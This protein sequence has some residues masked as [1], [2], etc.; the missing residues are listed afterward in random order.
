MQALL[1]LGNLLLGTGDCA[2]AVA[3]YDALLA[4]TPGGHWRAC[5]F[6]ASALVS[7]GRVEE[8]CQALHIASQTAGPLA[9][10]D[11]SLVSKSL[12][13]V[14]YWHEHGPDP[15]IVLHQQRQED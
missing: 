10:P 1:N 12:T 2:E 5:L 15:Q 13:A 14:L 4:A 11:C 6:R 8:A 3:C 9:S 7:L